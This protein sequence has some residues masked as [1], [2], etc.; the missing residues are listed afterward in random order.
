VAAKTMKG[1]NDNTI[2]ALPHEEVISILKKYN[3]IN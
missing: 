2:F 3:R 1:I